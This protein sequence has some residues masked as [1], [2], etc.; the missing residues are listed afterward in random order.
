[1]LLKVI[2]AVRQPRRPGQVVAHEAQH[3]AHDVGRHVVR[4]E[5]LGQEFLQLAPPPLPPAQV[6]R[7]DGVL[8]VAAAEAVIA[9]AAG[10]ALLR[11][12]AAA[13]EFA[14]PG[15]AAHRP[16]TAAFSCCCLLLASIDILDAIYANIA[17]KDYFSLNLG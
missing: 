3:D 8:A 10:R 7:D 5:E 11:S 1:M 6:G 12:A 4:P 14:R 16:L 9:A 2:V 15:P 13:A 17:A